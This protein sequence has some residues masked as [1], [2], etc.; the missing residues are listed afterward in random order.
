MLVY[1]ISG[2]CGSGKTTIANKLVKKI[3]CTALIS[4]DSI[5]GQ[6]HNYSDIEWETQLK[7][8][9]QNILLLLDNYLQNNI[10]VIIDYVIEDELIQILSVLKK[11]DI[12]IRYIVMT[13]DQETIKKRLISRGDAW[14]VERALYLN[15]KLTEDKNNIKYL[16]N[17]MDIPFDQQ[18]I[19]IKEFQLYK[20]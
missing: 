13:A 4:G 20:L 18:I 3:P 12:E 17:G 8:T 14:L 15:E 5:H 19:D 11:Y 6:V 9:W 7:I 2:C 10:N 1:I 16:Y